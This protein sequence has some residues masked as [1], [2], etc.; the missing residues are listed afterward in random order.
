MVWFLVVLAVVVLYI[1]AIYNGLVTSRNRTEESAATIDAQLKRR[2]DLI[3]NLVETVKGYATHE[4][5]TLDAVIKA[6]NSAIKVEGLGDDKV[7]A[8]QTLASSLKSVFALSEN[9]PDLKANE[10]FLELQREIADTETKI[11]ASRQFYN[12]CVLD[13]NNKIESFPDNLFANAFGF[14][15]AQYFELEEGEKQAVKNAPKVSF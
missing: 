3:P 10:N 8:E 1:V 7:Q 15:K 9:Y 6:R 12:T 14:S 13:L 4:K 5:S 2:Y 11:Q